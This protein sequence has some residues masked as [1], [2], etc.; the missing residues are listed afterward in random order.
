MTGTK[1]RIAINSATNVA[2]HF[3]RLFI[4]IFMT[5]FLLHRLG[6]EVYG[7]IPLV[8]SCVAYLILVS[9]GI[10]GSVGR[11][12]TLNLAK[13]QYDE[14]NRYINT[15]LALLSGLVALSL[16]P[17]TFIVLRFPSLFQIPVGHENEARLV[18]LMLGANL[19]IGVLC[20]PLGIG[21]YAKQRFDLRNFI[22]IS[23][24]IIQTGLIIIAFISIE[25]NIIYLAGAMLI[26]NITST[27]LRIVISKR[28]IPTL[29]I[30]PGLFDRAKVKEIGSYSS[31]VVVSH[32]SV[33]LFLN[34]DYIIINKLLGSAD[35]TEYSLAARWGEMIRAV[36]T[37]A[38]GVVAPL[39]TQM[40][41]DGNF[42]QLRTLLVRGM[43]IVLLMVIPP[44]VLLTIFSRELLI[45]WVGSEHLAAI[46]VFWA[47]LL[48]LAIN[49]APLPAF[50]I[51]TGMGKVKWVA[52]VTLASAIA[53]LAFSIVLVVWFNMGILGVAVGTAIS[54]SLKNLIFIPVYVTRVIKASLGDYFIG[55][56]Q[57]FAAALPMTALAI[58]FQHQFNL[59]GWVPLL[60]ASAACVFV[61]LVTSYLW[62]LRDA[63][64]QDLNIVLSK[65]GLVR[66]RI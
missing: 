1:K 42:E 49:L 48:P 56:M 16:I 4:G 63:D 6:T 61:F 57:P 33:L 28:L 62:V 36:A 35:V 51:L 24:Q 43:R 50:T 59:T 19:L 25:A 52:I 22:E 29:K 31:W 65:L 10:Q 2:S 58:F 47:T 46:P 38:V 66:E 12:V 3:L 8:N 17:F 45:T 34:T 15:A 54:L 14:A 60:S 40:E 27:I 55:L 37:A 7:I 53:N 5:P 30:S 20:S 13:R 21:F 41:V 26:T 11:Y 32:V 18:M 44:C 23:S 9:G 64:R 39:A